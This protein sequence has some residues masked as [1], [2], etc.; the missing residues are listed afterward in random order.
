MHAR[1]RRIDRHDPVDRPEPISLLLHLSEHPLPGAIL[2]PPREAFVDRVPPPEPFWHVPPGGTG[3]VFPCHALDCEP[4]IRPWARTPIRNRH[5]WLEHRPHFIR[6][7]LTYCHGSSFPDEHLRRLDQ[8][9]LG[10]EP[11]GLRRLF[12]ECLTVLDREASEVAETTSQGHF[13]DGTFRRISLQ[14]D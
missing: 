4:V 2:R 5:Q 7:L 14:Q 13:G 8:H 12:A 9:A 1:D 11:Q 6:D 10:E 3:P